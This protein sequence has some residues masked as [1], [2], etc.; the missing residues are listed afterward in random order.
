[1]RRH[2]A[3]PIKE[4]L[5]FWYCGNFGSHICRDCPRRFFLL[6]RKKS[7]KKQKASDENLS[8]RKSIFRSENFTKKNKKENGEEAKEA[9]KALIEVN[10]AS[11]LEDNK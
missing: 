2:I 3:F 9:I 10:N 1:M 6:N 11:G 4:Q 7:P 8:M 5:L